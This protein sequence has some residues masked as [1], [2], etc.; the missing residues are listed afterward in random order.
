MINKAYK[1]RSAIKMAIDNR[2][3]TEIIEYVID[4]YE[5]GYVNDPNDKGGE[6]KYGI[7]KA[8]YPNLDIKNLTKDVAIDLYIKHFWSKFLDDVLIF[9][10]YEVSCRAFAFVINRNLKNGVKAMQNAL[11]QMTRDYYAVDELAVDGLWGKQSSTRLQ[12]VTREMD[13]EGLFANEALTNAFYLEMIKQYYG[14]CVQN[15]RA[16]NQYLKSWIRRV[17]D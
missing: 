4:R 14:L 11:N 1:E 2:T 8:T 13:D 16:Y 10:G 12:Y 7:T 6:T 9:M 5:G 17:I 15:P 3:K